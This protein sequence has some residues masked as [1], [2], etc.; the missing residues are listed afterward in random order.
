M[1]HGE[2]RDRERE[3]ERE[4]W[5]DKMFQHQKIPSRDPRI[6]RY[7]KN[8]KFY[9]KIH[10]TFLSSNS[11]FPSHTDFLSLNKNRQL[12]ARRTSLQRMVFPPILQHLPERKQERVGHRQ[13][14]WWRMSAVD[15]LGEGKLYA[16]VVGRA[17]QCV[18]W[19]CRCC[20][21]NPLL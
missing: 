1:K 2:V 14:R 21:E 17:A 5:A 10:G 18:L 16:D 3:R 4:R 20:L 12:Q 7:S 11:T 13:V 19:E 15:D 9:V 6:G 8:T